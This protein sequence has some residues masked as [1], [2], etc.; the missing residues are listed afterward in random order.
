MSRVALLVGFV[1]LGLAP[2]LFAA[3][4]TQPLDDA[5]RR[6]LNQQI[7]E[8]NFEQVAFY[9]LVGLL[10]DILDQKILV[11]WNSL[12]AVDIDSTA[13][14]TIKLK[15]VKLSQVMAALI[16]QVGK[17]KVTW[18]CTNGLIYIATPDWFARADAHPVHQMPDD[19]PVRKILDRPIEHQLYKDAKVDTVVATLREITKQEFR[20]DW[21]AIEAA[22]IKRADDG[23]NINVS[24]Y[25][26][27]KL[28][29]VVMFKAG[30]D[31]LGWYVSDNV[32]VITTRERVPAA[33]A[34][35][36]AN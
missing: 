23:L 4:A 29:D 7:G 12:N 35:Q 18:R 6:L 9:D 34:S 3:P 1:I 36:P 17:D 27:W 24:N 21:P 8:G 10:N 13:A 14:V 32:I 2:S 16:N 30:D 22:G 15:N 26:L 11:S 25:P 19:G 20:I 33:A 5:S 31:K 28:L